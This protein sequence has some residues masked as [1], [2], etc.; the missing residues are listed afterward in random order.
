MVHPPFRRD[1]IFINSR[2][3]FPRSCSK[4]SATTISKASGICWYKKTLYIDLKAKDKHNHSIIAPF[5]SDR[6]I[7]TNPF[8]SLIRNFGRKLSN[9]LYYPPGPPQQNIQPAFLYVPVT[10]ATAHYA[11]MPTPAQAYYN[12]VPNMA[13]LNPSQV[14]MQPPS[15]VQTAPVPNYMLHGIS[16]PVVPVSMQQN[17]QQVQQ[18]TPVGNPPQTIANSYHGPMTVTVAPQTGIITDSQKNVQHHSSYTQAEPPHFSAPTLSNSYGKPSNIVNSAD[19]INDAT[20]SNAAY[21]SLP[22]LPTLS[23]NVQMQ[24]NGYED[25]NSPSDDMLKIFVIRPKDLEKMKNATEAERVELAKGYSTKYIDVEQRAQELVLS[26]SVNE[27]IDTQG[28]TGC[29]QPL[30][31]P[32]LG[33]LIPELLSSTR[34]VDEN[35]DPILIVKNNSDVSLNENGSFL[36]NQRLDFS[37]E[38]AEPDFTIMRAVE[39]M[40]GNGVEI[41]Q[42]QNSKVMPSRVRVHFPRR[43]F[44]S[45]K[46][47]NSLKSDKSA[48]HPETRKQKLNVIFPRLRK[49]ARNYTQQQDSNVKLNPSIISETPEAP[50]PLWKVT[51][52]LEKY[53]AASYPYGLKIKEKQKQRTGRNSV[54]GADQKIRNN[55]KSHHY[56]AGVL[57]NSN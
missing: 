19:E 24:I 35:S 25:S 21:L 15:Q 9:S 4:L 11:K 43:K 44:I 8:R 38:A 55:F 5:A 6:L 45:A 18:Y 33:K 14:Q 2:S 40:D 50:V 7:L 53:E 13:M 57:F 3:V 39:G 46:L 34:N 56:T 28:D 51:P 41:L 23:E 47:G 20:S 27:E 10:Q 32:F 26:P 54:N 48:V 29:I 1:S 17:Q 30:C 22:F 52:S 12:Q 36:N 42:G 49:D 31:D 16:Y 37:S